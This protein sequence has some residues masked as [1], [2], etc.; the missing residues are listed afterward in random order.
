M[1]LEDIKRALESVDPTVFYGKASNVSDGDLWNYI[2]FSRDKLRATGDKTGIANTYQV[3][4]V[5]ENYIQ[6]ETV[7]AVIDAMYGLAGMR[8]AG[9][10]FAYQYAAKPKTN[11][12]IELLVLDFVK[13]RKG[14]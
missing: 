4:I 5:R 9:N 10:E 8:L 12:I 3:A 2:V 14:R 7:Q 13:P 6:E 11:T 1:I